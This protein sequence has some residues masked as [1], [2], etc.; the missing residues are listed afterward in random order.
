MPREPQPASR[1]HGPT[2]RL[3]LAYVTAVIG[4]AVGVW[5]DGRGRHA[6]DAAD[7]T[8]FVAMLVALLL[9]TSRDATKR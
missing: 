1:R 7:G 2:L 5:S 8:V 9:L 4:L 3:A 6:P